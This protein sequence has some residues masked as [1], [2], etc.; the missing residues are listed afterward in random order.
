MCEFD[1]SDKG[2]VD[3]PIRECLA[4]LNKHASFYTTSSCSGRIVLLDVPESGKKHE[5]RFLLRCHDEVD[6][7]DV[8]RCVAEASS[9]GLLWLRFQPAIL[10]LCARTIEDAQRFID[11]VRPLGFK[12]CG[13]FSLKEE[14]LMI[15]MIGPEEL[16]V[17]IADR[18]QVWVEHGLLERFV[19]VANAM[20]RRNKKRLE[21]VTAAV[22]QL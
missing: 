19:A 6:P 16:A 12:R 4:V 22:K 7:E 9:E 15:E 18:E 17:P 11:V 10:H 3:E 5:A 14:R 1:R 21:Q 8:K 20:M 2:S 13:I